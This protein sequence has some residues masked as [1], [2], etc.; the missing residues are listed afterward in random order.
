MAQTAHDLI[1]GNPFGEVWPP[2]DAD[3]SNRLMPAED[4]RTIVLRVLAQYLS[5]LTFYRPGKD[6]K[7]YLPFQIALENILIEHPDNVED[8]VLPSIVIS[9]GTV[10]WDSRGLMSQLDE[11]TI[12]V[13]GPGTVLQVLYEHKETIEIE[14][15]A[16][17]KPE[18]RSMLGAIQKAFV[19]TEFM[20]GVRFRIPNY[21]NRM[22]QFSAENDVLSDDAAVLG[23]RMVKVRVNMEFEV[24]ALKNYTPMN[25]II[26]V[27]VEPH[28]VTPRSHTKRWTDEDD[29]EIITG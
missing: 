17:K 15:W 27:I 3:K 29:I 18:R 1:Q 22:A 24:V 23:R 21:Y 2:S 8:L 6:D 4:P 5:E 12:D 16:A 26:E 19:P 28:R 14:C 7:E 9:S 10:E 25:P 11:S 20:Y 13:Y